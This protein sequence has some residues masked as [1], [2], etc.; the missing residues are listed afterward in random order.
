[1]KKLVLKPAYFHIGIY[2]HHRKFLQFYFEGRALEFQV[3]PFGL[4]TA[5]TF[6]TKKIES[7]IAPLRERGLRINRYLDDYFLC[8]QSAQQAM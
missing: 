3:H 7:V 5:P 4:A 2:I 1:M 6:F 8:A